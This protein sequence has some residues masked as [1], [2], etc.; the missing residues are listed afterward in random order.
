MTLNVAPYEILTGVGEI[1]LAPTGT[2]FPALDATPA[3]EWTHLGQTQDG[4]TVTLDQSIEEIRT[5]QE[6]GPR[7]ATRTEESLVL[8]TKLVAHTLENLAFVLGNEVTDNPP[9]VGTIGTRAVGLYRGQV[10][11][12]YAILFRGTSAYGDFPAQYEV[13]VGYFGGTLESEYTKDGN[14][15]VPKYRSS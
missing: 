6:T 5:D 1:Y 12:T 3:G 11:K 13:P 7:K 2:A 10:V 14:A 9:G 8:E 15:A 4:V